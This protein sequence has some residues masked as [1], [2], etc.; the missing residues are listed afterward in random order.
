MK[1]ILIIFSFL[2]IFLVGCNNDTQTTTQTFKPYKTGDEI[3]LNSVVDTN[4][5]IVR[6]EDGFKLKNSNKIIMFDI[7][8]TFC[9]PCQQEAPHLMDYQ[10][11]HADDFMI[12][13]L[14]YFEKITDAGI[15]DNFSKK[16]NA[17]YFITNSKENSRLVDQILNDI[18]YKQALQIPF[19]V[20]LK[21]G[22]YQ[23]LSDTVGTGHLNDFYLGGV[24]TDQISQD[25][26]RI[27]SEN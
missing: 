24:E 11:K 19:K 23:K 26:D 20:V 12:I 17:Y 21:N 14:I 25:I 1:K 27:K 9:P 10:L 7:F 6:T 16:Y 4:I 8:G 22:I 15:V 18:N 2:V 3:T 5:T 13:G